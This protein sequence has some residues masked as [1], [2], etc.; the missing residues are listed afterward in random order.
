MHKKSYILPCIVI[1]ISVIAV[2]IRVFQL[3]VVV[4]YNEM[5][6][7]STTTDISGFLAANGLYLLLGFTVILLIIGAILDKKIGSSSYV[8]SAASLTPKQTAVLGVAFLIGA[9]LRLYELALNF[10]NP[11][12]G[13]IGEALIFLLFIIMGF[14]ILCSKKF[15]P[16][17]GYL[18]II[19][20]ISYTLKAAVLFMQDTIIVRV[21]DELLL[22]LSYVASV[23]FFLALGRFIT[24]NES[25]LTRHK[26]FI[27]GGFTILLSLCA[28]LAGYIAFAINTEHIGKHMAMHPLSETGTAI[29][30]LAVILT[31]Y[32]SKS[33]PVPED[34]EQEDDDIDERNDILL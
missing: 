2:L 22:L 8:R 28:S 14:V 1:I 9:C 32:S 10:N 5:G 17:V 24:G 30:A 31:I 16:A 27:F 34:S 7:F 15:K 13:F 33:L 23:L 18:H 11:D 29:V 26:L 20:C 6:F 12:L 25:R 19:I 3:L 21:S 4:D